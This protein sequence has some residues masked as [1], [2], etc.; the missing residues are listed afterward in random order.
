MGWVDVWRKLY[1]AQR[2]YTWTNPGHW[3]SMC[4][5]YAFLTPQ[6]SPRLAAA[7]HFQPVRE[8][9]LSDHAMLIIELD[10]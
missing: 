7:Q 3:F 1:P 5:D 10:K 2:E 8:L 9:K 6:L 4:L